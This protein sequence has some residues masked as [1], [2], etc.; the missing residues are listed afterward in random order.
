MMKFSVL[1]SVYFKENPKYLSE[2]IESVLNQTVIPSEIVIVKD[3]KLSEDLDN[4]INNYIKKYKN[5]FKIIELEKNQG[6]GVALEKGIVA[7]SYEII[8]RMDTDDI[9]KNDRFEKQLKIMEEKSLDIVGSNISEFDGEQENIISQRLVPETLEEIKKFSKR[10]NPFNHMTVMYK[11]E[12][13]LNA[14]NYK[15]FLWFEDYNLWVRA[16]LK[17]AKCYNI[18]ENLV[19]ART[20]REMFSRR[21]GIKYIKQE[22]KMQKFMVKNKYISLYTYGTNILERIFIRVLPN[23]IREIIYLIFLREN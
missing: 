16:L 18:Q 10:R 13:I 2:A 5:L 12:S 3:G 17:G 9:S 21:G 15:E 6:L 8:A 4:V 14:G 1:M 22:I 11:K 23:K 7:C 20:G 19:N